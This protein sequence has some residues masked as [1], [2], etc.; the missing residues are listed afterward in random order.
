M[1]AHLDS[2]VHSEVPGK[3][4]APSAFGT[5]R[6]PDLGDA[7]Q[8]D[9]LAAGLE[10]ASMPASGDLAAGLANDRDLFAMHVN[11]LEDD[12][13]K[14]EPFDSTALGLDLGSISDVLDP[15]YNHD[16]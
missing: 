8:Q 1:L 10:G 7:G 3:A 16:E 6:L 12:G 9:A 11:R 4:L 13:L 5:G 15:E 14:G 2:L